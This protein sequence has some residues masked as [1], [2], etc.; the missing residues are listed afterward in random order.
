MVWFRFY[1]TYLSNWV[2]FWY[3]CHPG[4]KLPEY[5]SKSHWWQPSVNRKE[6]HF[7]L[8]GESKRELLFE[9]EKHSASYILKSS[10]LLACSTDR[11]ATKGHNVGFIR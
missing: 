2:S 5:T 10:F 6:R 4:Y 11:V 7:K 8:Q 3:I 9:R 1:S